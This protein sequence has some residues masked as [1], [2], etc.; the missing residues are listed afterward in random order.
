MNLGSEQT[1]EHTYKCPLTTLFFWELRLLS[2]L[3]C[4]ISENHFFF[5]SSGNLSLIIMHIYPAYMQ[6][7]NAANTI[8]ILLWQVASIYFIIL[9]VPVWHVRSVRMSLFPLD[10]S[11]QLR[12]H[13][14][15]CTVHT[16]SIHSLRG[17]K[18]GQPV[19]DAHL[20]KWAAPEFNCKNVD[21]V[22]SL[23]FIEVAQWGED[24]WPSHVLGVFN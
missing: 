18:M 14:H 21:C 9:V 20:P 5:R 17:F 19:S 6:D 22:N 4:R 24:S 1:R 7:K 8:L 23:Y 12:T 3:N 10:N 2:H 11:S 15:L 13:A 16:K